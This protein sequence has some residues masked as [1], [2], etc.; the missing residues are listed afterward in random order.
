MTAPHVIT[1]GP[2]PAEIGRIAEGVDHFFH[3][4]GLPD[5]ERL[6]LTLALDELAT[7]ALTYGYPDGCGE[8]VAVRVLLQ[9][10]AGML[11]A[12]LEDH[13]IA[14]NPLETPEPDTTL[15]IEERS[16]GGLGVHFVRALM[17]EVAYERDGKTNRLT[18]RKRVPPPG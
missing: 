11:T 2:N 10:Q 8:E 1:L 4:H 9:L 15:G 12:V 18:L 3:A 5:K 6:Q 17:D 14:F 7:N 16:I 13:G